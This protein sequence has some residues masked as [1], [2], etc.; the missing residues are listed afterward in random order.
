M[1]I[2]SNTL[3]YQP[4]RAPPQVGKPLEQIDPISLFKALGAIR[5]FLFFIY[6]LKS[7]HEEGNDW[8]VATR[9]MEMSRI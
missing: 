6:S 4:S 8:L 9:G 1:E 3:L 7:M 2:P 5:N